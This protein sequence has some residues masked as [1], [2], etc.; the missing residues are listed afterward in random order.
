[1]AINRAWHEQHRLPRNASLEERLAW[2]L[3]HAAACGCREMPPKIRRE[4]ESRG[5]IEPSPQSLR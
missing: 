4:L 3:K 1:M 5:L 2:H